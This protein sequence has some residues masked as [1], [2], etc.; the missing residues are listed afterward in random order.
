MIQDYF[1]IS[2]QM[3]ALDAEVMQQITES[4]AKI[5]AIKEDNQLKMLQAFTRCRVAANHLVGSTG[6]GYDDAGRAKLEEI[7]ATLTGSEAALFR[8]N[9]MSGTH[10]LT[11]A[12]FGLLRPG[13]TLLCASGRPYDTLIGVLGIDGQNGQG[14][15][16]EYGVN[17]RQIELENSR[18]NLAAIAQ[19]APGCKVLYLQRSRGYAARQALSLADIEAAA[20]AAKAVNPNIAVVVDNCYGEFTQTTEPTQ[21]GAD[22][23]VGS[24]IKNPGGGIAPTGGYIAGKAPLVELCAYRLTAP[25]VGAEIGCTGELMRQLYLGLYYAPGVTAAALKTSVYASAL[26]AR[27]GCQVSPTW[28]QARNDIITSIVTGSPEKL[29]ALCRGVQ[30]ASPVDSFVSPEP[31]PMPGY[32]CDVI[33]AAGAFTLGSSIELS[34]DA[35]MKEPYTAYMQ[36]GLNFAASRAGV[37]LAAQAAFGTQ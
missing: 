36:G 32:D 33:M 20:A 28:Q 35:P 21:H 25:G 15:L 16:A 29:V 23:I 10:A 8:H 37:L 2:P 26:F 31:W 1:S 3:Q 27:L 18:P 12:L 34:C 13:D 24:L 22:L 11:V 7:F 17:Y 4:L 5:D 9:F 19:Q 14:S 6:Y 30:S